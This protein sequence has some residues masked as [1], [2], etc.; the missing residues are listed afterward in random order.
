MV[1]SSENREKVEDFCCLFSALRRRKVQ[2]PV[3]K[4]DSNCGNDD[5]GPESVR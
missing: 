5:D 2:E 4:D 1:I 3:L